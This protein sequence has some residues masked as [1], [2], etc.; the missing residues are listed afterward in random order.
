[1]SRV[2]HPFS[3][4]KLQSLEACPCYEGTNTDSEASRAGTRQHDAVEAAED[5]AVLE[6]HQAI[7]VAQCVAFAEKV[8]AQYPGGTILKEQYLP[9]D[10]SRI[11]EFEGTTAGYLDFSIISACGTKAEIVDYKF[12]QHAV[13]PA[14]NNLQGIAYMLGLKRRFPRLQ[15]C[16][17]QFVMPHR[18]E[19]DSHTF[20]LTD[21][22]VAK[23]H[24]RIRAIVQRAVRSRDNFDNAKPSVSACLFCA[25]IGECPRI[26]ETA[27]KVGQKFAPL[28]IPANVTPTL[29][30]DPE[31]TSL[32]I[33]LAQVMDAWAKSFRAR[34]T[35]KAVTDPDFIP[36]GYILVPMERR[37]V[38]SAKKVIDIAKQ[39]LP[40]EQWEALDSLSD[41][42]ITKV[43]ALV[44][45]VSP[46]GQKGKVVDEMGQKLLAEGAVETGN[47]FAILKQQTNSKK[48][49]N[50]E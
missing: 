22:E 3:P 18:D 5:N 26:V 11:G 24:T 6:D 15:L 47:P 36:E 39:F 28:Q 16:R 41:I 33:K 20:K 43:E 10:D 48:E 45:L 9:I 30:Q 42:P 40:P 49:Q 25:R 34:A 2:H 4:S 12:G 37:K 35:E 23:H 31:D 13:E 1:M 17:V 19:L 50:N 44:K 8:A 29:I 21:E 38:I 46:R 14:E 27:L 32:G 7:A